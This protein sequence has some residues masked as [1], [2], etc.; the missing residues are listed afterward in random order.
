M[1]TRKM[2]ALVQ[3]QLTTANQSEI[4]K[5]HLVS[6]MAA[7]KRVRIAV[8]VRKYQNQSSW[9]NW[10][11]RPQTRALHRQAFSHVFSGYSRFLLCPVVCLW[12]SRQQDGRLPQRSG[13]AVPV[14]PFLRLHGNQ[15]YLWHETTSHFQ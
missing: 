14:L 10:C 7:K 12:N 1:A 3:V 9:S 4:R 2:H 6:V 5:A 8:A 11:N 15:E 13:R